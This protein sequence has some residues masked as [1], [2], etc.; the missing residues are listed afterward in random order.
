M[1][2]EPIEAWYCAECNSPHW[3]YEEAVECCQNPP[4]KKDAYACE[5][6]RE[7]YRSKTTADECC[8][9]GA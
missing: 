6:C 1:N 7:V 3:E 9:D 4:E 2:A 5:Q 8:K